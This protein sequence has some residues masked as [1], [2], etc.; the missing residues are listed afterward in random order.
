MVDPECGYARVWIECGVKNMKS[1]LEEIQSGLFG[2]FFSDPFSLEIR[3][4]PSPGLGRA[5]LSWGFYGL[6]QGRIGRE[7]RP[8][9]LLLL[10]P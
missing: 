6:F 7:V 10:F 9:F 5:L 2:F 4:L 3:M 8:T 1:K